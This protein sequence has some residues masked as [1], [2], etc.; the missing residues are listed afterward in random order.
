MTLRL[1]ASFESCAIN[2]F[3]FVL[4]SLDGS[5]PEP[6][7]SVSGAVHNPPNLFERMAGLVAQRDDLA[8]IRRQPLQGSFHLLLAFA[9]LQPGAGRGA[10]VRRLGAAPRAG[11]QV[12]LAFNLAL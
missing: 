5:R 3:K 7:S 11:R 8:I 2:L 9:G 1:R 12:H 6:A 4:E 10:G